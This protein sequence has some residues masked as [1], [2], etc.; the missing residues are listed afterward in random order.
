MY[1]HCHSHGP[2]PYARKLCSDDSEC[3]LGFLAVPFWRNLGPFQGLLLYRI[4]I[5]KHKLI[6]WIQL[7]EPKNEREYPAAFLS[8][9]S[10]SMEGAKEEEEEEV[11]EESGSVALDRHLEL[12]LGFTITWGNFL[13]QKWQLYGHGG[14]IGYDTANTRL[15]LSIISNRTV[16]VFV[17]VCF[18]YWVKMGEQWV[19]FVVE[20]RLDCLKRRWNL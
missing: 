20:L 11:E 15:K 14:V 6:T 17:F 3:Y 2:P 12:G 10:E 19:S 8:V 4:W 1:R 5:Q 16:F 18:Y 7:F 9:G 13:L